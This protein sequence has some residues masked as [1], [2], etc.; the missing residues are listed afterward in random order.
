M[1]QDSVGW[2]GSHTKITIRAC[3]DADCHGDVSGT[4]MCTVY[5][6]GGTNGTCNVTGRLDSEVDAHKRFFRPLNASTSNYTSEDGTNYT[7]GFYTCLAC[8]SHVSYNKKV[9][10][11]NKFFANFTIDVNGSSSLDTWG[12]EANFTN[13]TSEKS[14]SAWL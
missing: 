11:P 5:T 1:E 14:G 13:S 9:R 2:S 8:H 10:R 7:A 4:T 12:I 6:D 3:T